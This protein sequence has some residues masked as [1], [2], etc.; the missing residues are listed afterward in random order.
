M[1][2][3]T[4]LVYNGSQ[5]QEMKT[6]DLTN[7]YRVAAYYYGLSPSVTLTVSGSGGNLTSI[8]DTRFRHLIH[9]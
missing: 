6:S 3:R 4:P 8:N 5:L 9:E 1:T 7:A 2:V